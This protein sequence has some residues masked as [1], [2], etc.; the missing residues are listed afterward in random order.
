M[1]VVSTVGPENP[2]LAAEPF[3]VGQ[4]GPHTEDGD[5]SLFLMAEAAYL[6]SEN[7]VD[8]GE[9]HA[10]GFDPVDVLVDDLLEDDLL[11][12]AIVCEPCATARHIDATD[13]R[14]WATIGGPADLGRMSD[15]HDTTL[16]F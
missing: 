9:L 3:V 8:L 4:A 16:S 2:A 13:L 10:P 5:I 15:E 12:E 6:V 7:H 11:R 14:D 1:L